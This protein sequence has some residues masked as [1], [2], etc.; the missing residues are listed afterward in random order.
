MPSNSEIHIDNLINTSKLFNDQLKGQLEGYLIQKYNNVGVNFTESSPYG[1]IISVLTELNNLQYFYLSD[2]LTERNLETAYK[3]KSVHGLARLTGHNPSRAISARGEIS[4]KI[5]PGVSNDIPGNNITLNNNTSLICTNNGEKYLLRINVDTVYVPKTTQ[6][7]LYFTLVQGEPRTVTYVGNATDLQSY[8]VNN[9]NEFVENDTVEIYVN[10]QEFKLFES[11]YDMKK[12]E[13]GAIVKTGI[14]GGIDVFFGNDDYGYKPG[15]GEQ[16]EIRYL[17]TAGSKGNLGVA[18][19]DIVFE[20]EDEVSDGFGGTLD[21]NEIF[22]ISISKAIT[23]GADAEGNDLTRQLLNKNS[24]A[25]V[26]ANPDNYEY[27][28]ARYN[29]FSYIDAYNTVDDQYLDDD[30]VVYLFIL[31]DISQKVT[32]NSDY[33]STNIENFYLTQDDKD[34]VY[35]TI[36]MS[37]QQLISTELS[38][39]DPIITYYALN[40]FIRVFDDIPSEDSVK[41]EITNAVGE[42]FLN[43]D[44]RDKIPR[45]DIVRIVEDIDGVDSVFV[46]F[47]SGKNETAILDGFYYKQINYNNN[48]N[49]DI[50]LA[51]YNNANNDPLSNVDLSSS[52]TTEEKILVPE[53][54]D[55]NLG[56]DTFGDI[57]IGR[58][59]LPLVRGGFTDRNGVEYKNGINENNLSALNIIISESIK[60]TN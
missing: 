15:S 1:Q 39:V 44:R 32:S 5:K 10:G 54:T 6:D 38:I 18:S 50:L 20:F 17:S 43:I 57:V 4:L 36:N 53:G 46:E 59:E 8:N 58:D 29:Q 16:I 11:L 52:I 19:S 41:A 55:P 45:S 22:D 13:L 34:A 27:F 42:Y 25:L 48:Q 51:E 9:N 2:A 24:R 33:F 56:L 7:M 30:N 35:D 28:L 26:L 21:L 12:G 14:N 60:R 37:G 47:I 49:S 31:P 3:Q 40:I 23:L